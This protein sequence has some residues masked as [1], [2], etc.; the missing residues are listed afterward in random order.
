MRNVEWAGD[1]LA[2]LNE[3]GVQIALDDFGTGYSSLSYLK[4][5]PIDFIKIDQSSIPD[6]STNHP[7]NDIT[8]AIIA[9]SH[10]LGLFTIAEG[11]ETADQ[12]Q[13]LGRQGCDQVQGF[14]FGKAEPPEA[15]WLHLLRDGT[16]RGLPL[17]S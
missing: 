6:L 16:P 11:V 8:A 2:E 17:A 15:L 12:L 10:Q 3:L 4:R 1:M 5:L 7:D 13:I 14:L 9:M